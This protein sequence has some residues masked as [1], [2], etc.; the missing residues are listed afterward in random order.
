MIDKAVKK[1][2]ENLIKRLKYIQDPRN[3]KGEVMA[4]NYYN[5][6]V[7]WIHNYYRFA[8]HINLNC[9]KIQRA[10]KYFNEKSI[11]GAA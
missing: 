3:K 1:E 8:T 5:S 11:K 9:N 6:T 4:I 7:W 10:D 2:T